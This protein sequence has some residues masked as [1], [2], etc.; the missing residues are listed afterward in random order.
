MLNYDCPY[1]EEELWGEFGESVYCEKCNK[2]FETDWD[3]TSYSSISCWLT[4]IEYIGN[5]V[6]L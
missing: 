5:E 2:T 3:Y 1:C 6:D 4:G